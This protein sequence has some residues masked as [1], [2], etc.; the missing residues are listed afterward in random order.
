MAVHEII[1]EKSV[2]A[3]VK[4]VGTFNNG[5]NGESTN[6]AIRKKTYVTLKVKSFAQEP[7]GMGVV[8]A[9]PD[10]WMNKYMQVEFYTTSNHV[11]YATKSSKPQEAVGGC[12]TIGHID[13]DRTVLLVE[14]R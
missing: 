3:L 1:E 11:G 5:Y 7:S 14:Y 8:F 2:K 13:A 4:V 9:I 10:E 12:S 6:D